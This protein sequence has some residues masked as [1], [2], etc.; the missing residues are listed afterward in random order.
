[1]A[2][3]VGLLTAP[4]AQIALA[5]IFGIMLL[6]ERL[7][8]GQWLGLVLGVTGVAL[9]VGEAAVESVARFQGLV[10]AFVGVLGLVAGTLYFGR[11]CRGVPLL[12]GATAQFLSAAAVASLGRGFGSASCGLD[13]D[14]CRSRCLEHRHGF[15]SK[16]IVVICMWTAPF[17]CFVSD[18]PPYGTSMPGAGAVHHIN[19]DMGG[20]AFLTTEEPAHLG[21]QQQ[22]P[23]TNA[24]GR[25][26]PCHSE[27]VPFQPRAFANFRLPSGDLMCGG[28]HW[29]RHG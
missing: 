24:E 17:M 2:P 22:K 10:L 20:V 14:C 25:E 4:A 5:A 15:S 6:H 16:P 9:V 21:R 12:P 26:L 8:M 13:A 11:F 3:H 23:R 29:L 19:S 18:E 28:S 7:R 27:A 1:M